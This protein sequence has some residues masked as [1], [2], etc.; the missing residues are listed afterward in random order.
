MAGA[1]VVAATVGAPVVEPV[2]EAVLL[3][4]P[5]PVAAAVLLVAVEEQTTA[6]GRLVWGIALLARCL[7]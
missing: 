5:L 7:G 1:L 2:L 6:V 4:L 3:E